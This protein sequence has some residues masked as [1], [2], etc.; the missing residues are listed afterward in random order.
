MESAAASGAAAS[1]TGGGPDSTS[2]APGRVA[3]DLVKRFLTLRE[4]SIIVVTILLGIYF[5]VNNATFFTSANFKT[6]LPYFAPFA[7][8]GAGEVFLMING[9]I[10]LS[11]GGAYL[12]APFLFYELNNGGV[13]LVPA[14]I[15]AIVACMLVGLLNGVFTAVI[16]VNSFVTT[17]GMLFSLE[18]LTLIISHAAPV[19]T[20]G[21]QVTSTTVNV[22]HIVNGH[23]IFLPQT[24]NHIGTFAEVFGGG[25]YSELIWAVVI[26]ALLQVVL[27]WTRWGRYT[28]AVGSNRLGAAEAGVRVRLVMIRNFVLCSTLAGLVGVLEAVRATSVQPDPAGA[29]VVLFD[30]ISAAVIGGTLLAGGSGTVVGALIG[31]LFLGILHDGLVIQGVNANYL[32]FYLGLAILLAMVVNVYV[33]RVR[34][35]SGLG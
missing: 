20:P 11:I 5:S 3:L 1:A 2:R 22:P 4:G 21:A 9:E 6:L 33:G 25:T 8:L 27:V 26:V 23:Q 24:V 19:L 35:G 18:G 17:L 10:D 31:A 16:G 12:F 28:V 34:R 7:I 14:V 13:P 15:I 29:N 30:G 32:D